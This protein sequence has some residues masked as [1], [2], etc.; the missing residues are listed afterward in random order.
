MP[1]LWR[2]LLFVEEICFGLPAVSSPEASD[3]M[4][5]P[6]LPPCRGRSSLKVVAQPLE[7]RL[8]LLTLGRT[9]RGNLR[10]QL[11]PDPERLV[12]P[13]VSLRLRTNAISLRRSSAAE[14]WSNS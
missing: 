6:V 11:R 7:H 2:E 14:V 12:L 3:E 5:A 1:C 9:S 4:T 8:P 13:A 10:H